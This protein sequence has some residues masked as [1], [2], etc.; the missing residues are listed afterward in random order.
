MSLERFLDT[1]TNLG[2]TLAEAQ[3][4]VFLAKKG[5]H[6]Q[7]ELACALG[8]TKQQTHSALRGLHAK[9]MVKVTRE[10]TFQFSA[11]SIEKML[12]LMMKAKM[13]QAR[14]VQANRSEFLSMWRS[15]IL[16]K[17]ANN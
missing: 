16:K 13:E 3:T 12:D 10:P 15:M 17:P 9:G 5:P 14:D 6:R 11:I 7:K 4:Y 8:L 2:L 1:L